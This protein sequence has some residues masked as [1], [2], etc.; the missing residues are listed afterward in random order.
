MALGYVEGIGA[1]RPLLDIKPRKYRFADLD[2]AKKAAEAYDKAAAILADE[3]PD[4]H[5]RCFVLWYAIHWRLRAGGLS[6]RELR[7]RINAAK[8]ATAETKRFG[9]FLSRSRTPRD[10]EPD[11]SAVL[12]IEDSFKDI[13]ALCETQLK[14]INE[15]MRQAPPGITDRSTIKPVP[16]LNCTGLP[17]S[18]PAGSL[19][20]QAEFARLPGEIGCIDQRG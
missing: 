20:D 19:I 10:T 12:D 9:E 6:V 17:R 16:T 8:E 13:R 4:F 14:S 15:S 11:T 18:F 7:S 5:R 3:A 1:G 2:A